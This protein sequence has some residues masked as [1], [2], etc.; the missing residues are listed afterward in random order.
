MNCELSMTPVLLSSLANRFNCTVVGDDI[1]IS[2]FGNLSSVTSMSEKQLSFSISRSYT[3]QFNTSNVGACIVHTDVVKS[4]LCNPAKSYLVT[5]DN[6]E[7]LFYQIFMQFFQEN[8]FRTLEEGVGVNNS[9]ALTAVIENSVVIG[10]ECIIMDNVVIKSNTI[11][12]DRV[13]IKANSVIGGDGFQVK[14]I[15]GR[16]KIIPHAGGVHISDDV[17]IGSCVTIDKGLFGEFTSID[18]EVKIDNLVNIAHSTRIGR[19]AIIAAGV[20]LAGGVSI[21]SNVF[22]G[23]QASVNQLLTIPDYCY[24]GAHAAIINSLK[25]HQKV[26]GVPARRIGWVCCCGNDINSAKGSVPLFCPNCENRY[27]L[28]KE[29]DICKL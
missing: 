29:G 16:R 4:G 15:E 1:F 9:I 2:K 21:G 3:K 28:N 26:V 20:T 24:I 13:T 19:R 18:K 12:G 6:P 23:M 27:L 25:A 17:E 7:Q 11:I 5:S 10:N 22:I 8:A 14:E